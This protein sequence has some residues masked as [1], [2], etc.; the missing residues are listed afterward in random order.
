MTPSSTRA[1]ERGGGGV[2]GAVGREGADVQLVDDEVTHAARA[3]RMRPAKSARVDHRSRPVHSVGQGAGGRIGPA[4]LAVE[5]IAVARAG[6]D[7]V[8]Q[9]LEAAVTDGS[10][11]HD[12]AARG[13]DL[14]LDRARPR[15]PDAKAGAAAFDRGA[16]QV[17]ECPLKH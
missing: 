14:E 15:S 10:E 17:H 11:R 1:I 16:N 2:E 4:P 13:E 12:L 7:A 8:D 9:R 3:A 6:A 5:E